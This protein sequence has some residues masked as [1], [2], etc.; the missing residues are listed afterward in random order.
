M[1]AVPSYGEVRWR[2]AYGNDGTTRV[3]PRKMGKTL[4]IKASVGRLFLDADGTLAIIH[5]YDPVMGVFQREVEMTV[6]PM[7]WVQEIIALNPSTEVKDGPI[8]N[9]VPPQP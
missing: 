6:I 4:P 1:N 8:P 3:R 5:E 9:R 2:D 7:G